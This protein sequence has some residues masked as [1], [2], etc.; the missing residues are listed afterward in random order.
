MIVG[1]RMYDLTHDPL[2]LGLIGLA[3][4]IPALSLALFAGYVVDH[5]RPLVIYRRVLQGSLISGILLLLSQLSQNGFSMTAQIASLY[6]ASFVSGIARGFSQPSL[7]AVVPRIVSREQLP[8]ASAWMSSVMQISRISGPALGGLVFGWFGMVVA[9]GFVC[10]SFV[11]AFA[12]LMLIRSNPAPASSVG[13][14]TL[15]FK[16]ELLSG[17]KFVFGH[18]ILLPALSLD[19]ISVL[20]GGVTALLPIFAAD[21]LMV[22][23]KGLGMLRAAPAI[24]ATIM[25]LILVRM[26]LRERAG[27]WLITSVAGFGISILVFGISQNFFLSILALGLSGAFDSVSM[28]IRSAAVQLTSPDAMRGR[29]S[30]VNSIFIGS[31]NEIGEFESGVAA[32]FLGAVPAVIFGGV[33]C[34]ATVMA[35]AVFFPALRKMDLEKLSNAEVLG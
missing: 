4:A 21:I 3:E 9:A 6:A 24:G 1:W 16:E 20:F 15:S 17:A 25:S 26:H 30:A 2:S 33:I 12:A 32:R 7:Y 8:K 13:T 27:S 34:L 22:G 11:V 35:I 23:P 19:M 18:P 14:T 10:G 31:S 28:V 5:G 29:I